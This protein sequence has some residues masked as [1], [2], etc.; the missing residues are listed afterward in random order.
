MAV[1]GK[2]DVSSQVSILAC[3][4]PPLGCFSRGSERLPMDNNKIGT[5]SSFD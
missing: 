5:G 4:G 1:V 2:S 3:L